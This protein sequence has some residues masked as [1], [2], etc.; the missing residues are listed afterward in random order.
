MGNIFHRAIPGDAEIVTPTIKELTPKEVQIIQET[1]K[2]PS[3][4]VR[5]VA[6]RAPDSDFT[7]WLLQAMDSGE[8][9]FYTFLERFPEHQQKF[10]AFRDKPLA[11]LK[12]RS[13]PIEFLSDHVDSI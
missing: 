3:A 1:W 13:P 12:V 2:I 10:V 5:N 6:N 4:N 7:R 11:E 9:I 8:T